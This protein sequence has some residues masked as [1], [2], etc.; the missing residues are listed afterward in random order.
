MFIRSHEPQHQRIAVQFAVRRPD[1]SS[2][3]TTSEYMSH[4]SSQQRVYA[5]RFVPPEKMYIRAAV[6]ECGYDV[7]LTQGTLTLQLL[8]RDKNIS[9]TEID[10]AAVVV[11]TADYGSA[12]GWDMTEFDRDEDYAIDPASVSLECKLD[13]DNVQFAKTAADSYRAIAA[14]IILER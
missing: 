4:I 3:L 7:V 1:T 2:P 14:T 9:E 11:T 13:Y 5:P 6:L 12:S 8:K 10:T